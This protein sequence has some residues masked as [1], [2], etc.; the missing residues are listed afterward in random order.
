MKCLL[1][2]EEYDD[3]DKFLGLSAIESHILW[4]SNS[5]ADTDKALARYVVAIQKKI[6]ESKK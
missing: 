1:C 2:G 6:E 3:E 4:H 5:T